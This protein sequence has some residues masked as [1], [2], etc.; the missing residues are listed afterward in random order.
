M[1]ATENFQ[2]LASL[3]L[4]L[5]LSGVMASPLH[6]EDSDLSTNQWLIIERVTVDGEVAN[7]NTLSPNEPLLLSPGSH[8]IAFRY[9]P[10]ENFADR[11]L[12]LLHKLEGV[13]DDWQEAGGAMRFTIRICNAKNDLVYFQDYAAEGI[14]RE[15]HGTPTNSRF[16]NR[17]EVLTVNKDIAFVYLGLASG[18]SG[19]RFPNT[20]GMMVIDDVRV[21]VIRAETDE[22]AD[23]YECDFE[24]GTN[25]EHENGTP[26]DW[27]RAGRFH[28]E[29]HRVVKAGPAANNHAL[30]VL[31]N[32]PNLIAAWNC[33]LPGTIQIKQ[34]DQLVLRWKEMFT[35]GAGGLQTESYKNVPPGRHVFHVMS[36]TPLGEPD[37]HSTALTLIVPNLPFWRSPQFIVGLIMATVL[38]FLA[39]AAWLIRQRLKRQMERLQWQ[40]AVGLERAR[41]ARDIHD[42]LGTSLTRITMLSE[43]AQEAADIKS[44]SSIAREMTLAMD[45]I[46]WAVNPEN[47][48]LDGLATY[49]GGFAQEL[50]SSANLRCRLDLPVQLPPW[51]LTADAR[52][53]V[54]LAFKE[55]LN[56]VLKHSGAK[57]VSIALTV[58]PSQFILSIEDNGRG[59]KSDTNLQKPTEGEPAR[60]IGGHGLANMQSRMEKIGGAFAIASNPAGG[61]TV[62]FTIPV[63]ARNSERT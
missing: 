18:L 44:I 63:S 12:R 56:N 40:Q 36:T 39:E 31:D 34:G 37:G 49:L 4:I 14:S 53:N 57:E 43:V 55:A 16:T 51:S 9:G 30:A 28:T 52:H 48:S 58:K 27:A 1:P 59:L 29:M 22:E 3:G 60:V 32:G 20:L 50:L 7:T 2:R 6:G 15:W 47:D 17:K 46:V 24:T 26:D 25:M 13:D 41:I 35:V 5:L 61:T 54:F 8:R 23:L 45:E 62:T 33:K 21:S 19:G 38:I 42:D 11:P 10:Q